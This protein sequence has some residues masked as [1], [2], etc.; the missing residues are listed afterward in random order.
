MA[1]A[2][3]VERRA[4]HPRGH[5]VR[6]DSSIRPAGAVLPRPISDNLQRRFAVTRPSPPKDG[7]EAS[8]SPDRPNQSKQLV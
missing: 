8:L 6:R 4:R 5:P 7:G 1:H 3:A 2:R